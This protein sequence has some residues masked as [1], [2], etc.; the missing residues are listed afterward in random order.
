MAVIVNS[1]L[2]AAFT[3][4]NTRFQAAY[5][6]PKVFWDQTAMLVSSTTES[7]T[8]AWMAEVPKM[9]K[10]IGDRVVHSLST[11]AQQL[12]NDLY[13]D[14]FGVPR[15]KIDDDK[16]GVFAPRLT[17]M[18]RAAKKWPDRLVVTA[19][20]AA[21]TALA[22]DGQP[23]YYN[24]H[25]NNVDDPNSATFQ[26]LYDSTANGGSAATPLTFANYG[27]VRT[28][29]M[30][31]LGADGEPLNFV[32]DLLEV[33]P[34]LEPQAKQILNDESMIVAP[35]GGFGANAAQAQ[36]NIYRNSARLLVNP[37]LAN[38]PTR[39]YLH[40]T[41][42]GIL[43]FIFQLRDAVEFQFLDQPTQPHVVMRD[44]YIFGLRA[45]GAAGYSLP[46]LSACAA[47]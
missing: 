12:V 18:G 11:R 22:Y 31:L 38:E 39:W 44:E 8:Y 37:L 28:N 26:N 47:G 6:E 9:R 29:M 21:R 19:K 23:F 25:P 35:S 2:Q 7:E 41:S 4:F 45:R 36:S 10:W 34:Q 40:C 30:S 27:A 15:A 14:T 42:E 5:K 32:P 1:L 46:Q 33:P 17:M 24:A 43:P 20:Q 13:E 16:I 3:A